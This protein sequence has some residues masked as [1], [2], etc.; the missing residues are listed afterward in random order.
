M[1][2]VI[3]FLI[4]FFIFLI[5]SQ[6]FLAHFETVVEG[7][8]SNSNSSSNS[9]SNSTTTGFATV[10]LPATVVSNTSS[11]SPASSSSSINASTINASS[12]NSTNP[13]YMPYTSNSENLVTFVEQNANNIAYL[14]TKVDSLYSQVQ[15]VSGNVTTLNGSTAQIGKVND[16]ITKT[17]TS[18]NTS[19]PKVSGTSQSPSTINSVSNYASGLLS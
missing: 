7:L 19:P 1:K 11:V 17:Q 14:K 5:I 16:V 10:T 8:Q 9:S 12:I 18:L 3:Y 13:S 2:W 6:I 15:D 4:L